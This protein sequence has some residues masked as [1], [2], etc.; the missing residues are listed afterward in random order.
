[1]KNGDKVLVDG[2]EVNIFLFEKGGDKYYCSENE[3]FK[4][5][6]MIITKW[7]SDDR[8]TFTNM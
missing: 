4:D 2:N 3:W 5:D 7:Y 8:V 1:M 6:C